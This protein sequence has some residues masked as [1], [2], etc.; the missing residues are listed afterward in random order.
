METME[1]QIWER[2]ITTAAGTG[3]GSLVLASLGWYALKLY[4]TERDKRVEA[5]E[6]RS[7]ICE[8]D[9]IVLHA[10]VNTLQ[11]EVRKLYEKIIDKVE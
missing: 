5:L 10:E 3:L 4:L 8:N 9:R 7:Q 2:V 1:L 6:K 11:V